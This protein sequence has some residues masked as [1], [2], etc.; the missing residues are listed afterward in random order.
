MTRDDQTREQLSFNMSPAI[1]K[2]LADLRNAVRDAGHARPSQRTLV[3]AL[4][5]TAPEDGHRLEMK[6]LVPYRKAHPDEE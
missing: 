4:I 5:D 1:S 3:Q 2:R 6:V